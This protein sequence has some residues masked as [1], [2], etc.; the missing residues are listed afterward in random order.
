MNAMCWNQAVDGM[1]SGA[2]RFLVLWMIFTASCV[3][4][5]APA[6]SG[7]A[8]PAMGAAE[9]DKLVGPIAL[10]PDDLVS[11][12]LPAATYPLEIVQ[13]ARYLEKRKMDKNLPLNEAWQDSVKSLLN[14]PEVV[15][16]MSEDLDW[17]TDLGSCGYCHWFNCF[18]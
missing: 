1:R 3:F 18:G 11:I 15:K 7:Y 9:L 5:Q 10:Y 14:Y 4:A 13:A 12:I 16:K 8:A 17:T 6:A 2:S